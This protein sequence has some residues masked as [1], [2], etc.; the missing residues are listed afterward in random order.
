[1]KIVLA[2]DSFKGS[3]SA[4]QVCQAMEKGI[5]GVIKK[6]EI[7]KIPMADG[8][9]GTVHA[10]ISATKGHVERQEVVGPLGIAVMAEYGILGDG[11]TA[12][13]EMAAASGLPLVPFNL[14]NPLQTTTYG[15]GQ[16][17]LAAIEKGCQKIIIGIGGSATTDCG[18]G[19]AQALGVQFFKEDGKKISDF[20]NGY[21]MGQVSRLD[22]SGL[23]P[24]AQKM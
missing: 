24:Q 13:I 7:D 1:M 19:M 3:L 5:R 14:R 6:V 15:T 11:R 16:L 20:M 22:M 17:I 8:G 10:L 4:I 2:P 9:E 12:V 18:T 23:H 21:L